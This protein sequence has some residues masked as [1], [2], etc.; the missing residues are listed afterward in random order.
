LSATSW[1]SI[2]GRLKISYIHFLHNHNFC[3]TL[4]TF[5]E[6]EKFSAFIDGR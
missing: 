4:L 2:L 5:G 3:N 6:H 1:L